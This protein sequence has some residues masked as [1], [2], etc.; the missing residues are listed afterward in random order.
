MDKNSIYAFVLIGLV[1][2]GFMYYESSNQ[3]P[4]PPKAQNTAQVSGS[5]DTTIPKNTQVPNSSLPAN[6]VANPAS[7]DSLNRISQYGVFFSKFANQKEELFEIETENYK[8]IISNRGPAIKKFELKKYKKWNQ[9]QTQLIND[10]MGELYLQ[11]FSMDGRKIDSRDLAFSSK[12]TSKST[13]ENNHFNLSGK[14]SLKIDFTLDVAPG[15]IIRS[16]VFYGDSYIVEN[17]VDL[18]NMEH[19]IPQR[20]F[21]FVWGKGVR[22]QEKNSID[23]AGDAHAMVVMNG[24][25]KELDAKDDDKVNSSETGKI[26]YTAIKNKYFTAAIIPHNF[27]GTVDVTGNRKHIQDQGINEFYSMSYRIP[28]RGGNVK[29][30]FTVYM[31]PIDFKI[32][33]KYGLERTINF[34]WWI[35]RYIGQYFM[36]PLFNLIHNF[37]PNYGIA[38]I[39]F[40][41]LIKFLLYPLTIGQMKS[42]YKMK[43]LQPEMEKIRQK[44]ESDPTKQQQETMKLYSEYGLNPMGGCLPMLLQMPIMYALWSVLRSNIDLRQSTFILWITDLSMPDNIVHFG[45][46]ILGISA[47]SGLALLMGITMFIQQKMTVT[48]PRQQTMVYIMPVMFLFMFSSFPAGLNLYYFMFN[49]LSIAQQYW[50]NNFAPNRPTLE[51]LRKAPKKEGWL[52]KKMREAQEMAAQQQ[53]GGHNYNKINQGQAKG[54]N[55]GKK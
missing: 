54:K 28:Y 47:I 7:Y 9:Y 50:M 42:S 38:I 49:V 34:G 22:F 16:L 53:S 6:Q 21:E 32:I 29:Q 43:L 10:K 2:A 46:S 36:V 33:S 48:D 41:I 26:D 8:A 31:G 35:I 27:D 12:I 5:N 18:Q 55:Q 3:P 51:D 14:D 40:S 19:A 4:V 11:F 20:G 25:V 1:I 44:F 23:E 24:D 52:Q 37:I 13:S 30:D 39:I 15:K 17:S 45:F